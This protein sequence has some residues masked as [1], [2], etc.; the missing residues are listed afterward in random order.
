MYS[1]IKIDVSI[2]NDV[3]DLIKK[4][5]DEFGR[6]DILVNSAGIQTIRPFIE[7]PENEWQRVVDVNL[8]GTFLCSQGVAKEMIKSG[9][10]GTIINISSI[11]GSIPR[12]NEV[13]YDASKAGVDMLTKEM[14]LELA[15]YGIRVNCIAPGI[16]AT[17]MN[18]EILNPEGLIKHGVRVPLGRVGDPMDVARMAL[19]L[20][21]DE[22]NY[23]TG[24]IFTVDGGL[25][26]KWKP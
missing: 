15:E 9:V 10:K 1:P 7:L 22:A 23:I 25:S 6:I 2:S 17:P 19:F 11:H 18:K 5:L 12:P 21:S 26:L 3:E 14:A 4:T 24:G 16:I 20:A 8:K 13:H